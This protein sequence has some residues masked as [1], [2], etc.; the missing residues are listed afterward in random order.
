MFGLFD[1]LLGHS[2][3]CVQRSRFLR[4]LA[5]GGT[6]WPDAAH[7][8]WAEQ[9]VDGG[10]DAPKVLL[11]VAHPDDESECA[12]VIYRVTRELGGI[13]DQA[14]V[15]DGQA[16]FQWSGPAEAV[17]G[18]D[19][20]NENVARQHLPRIRRK[21]VLRANKI[22]GV[23]DTYFFDQLDTGMTFDPLEGLRAW[24]THFVRDA[25]VRLMDRERYDLILTLLPDEDTHGHHQ[26]VAILVLQ[27]VA[28]FP[29]ELRP[30]VVG[31]KT[32]GER[33]SFAEFLGREGFPLTRTT[34]VEPVWSFDRR[35]QLT[36][37]RLDYSI[38]VHWVIAEHKSQ[39]MFQMEFGRR[40]YEQFWLF[41][42][43]G[44]AGRLRWERVQER[45]G[46]SKMTEVGGRE[47]RRH[48][49]A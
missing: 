49:Y 44:C 37:S 27:A 48:A 23:R 34:S 35:T 7:L 25:L 29:E 28:E 16:G 38:I 10:P 20:G 21:E 26:S 36:N 4:L 32:A 17:Y 24:K 2:M 12:A 9:D 22:L 8:G 18:L 42:V 46:A 40:R 39:G 30:G 33:E 41:A 6:L 43:S 45:L 14:I 31:V 11:V 3:E 13:V 5:T 19:L 47:V 15:T 1:R